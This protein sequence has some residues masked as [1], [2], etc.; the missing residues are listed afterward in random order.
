MSKLIMFDY[1]GVIVDS[2]E[3]FCD[4]CVA[5][6]HAAGLPQY[7]TRETILAFHDMNWFAAFA[8]AGIPEATAQEIED[9][10]ARACDG[11]QDVRPF[12][13]IAKVV[14]TLAKEHTLIIITSSRT[15][16]AEAFLIAQG[17]VGITRVI[18]SD[19]ETS[20][21]RKIE[22]VKADYGAE[23]EYW[24]V[25]DTVGDIVEGKA[26]GVRTIAVGWGWH[27]AERL[28]AAS[29]DY[30]AQTPADLLEFLGRRPS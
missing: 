3:A 16:V 8:A 23:L 15:R 5:A 17:I 4:A 27:D 10:I 1:D 14:A 25:G 21:T 13:G 26:A 28:L 29:P 30:L 22:V 19:S 18:G 7:A 20:K 9:A 2:L 11:N 24:Y 12:L 6:F